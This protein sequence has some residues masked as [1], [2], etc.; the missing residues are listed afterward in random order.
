MKMALFVFVTLTLVACRDGDNDQPPAVDTA[1]SANADSMPN[2]GGMAT[3]SPMMK[4]MDAHMA[5]MDK[6]NPDSMSAMM[7]TH[8]Q[9][10]ANMLAQMNRDMQQMH[11]AADASWTALADS[12]R[13]DL[14]KMANMNRRD[15]AG[16][17]NGHMGRARRLMEL[18][19]RMM[20]D[21]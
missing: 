2:M 12:V 14:T 11:M 9:M 1:A 15:M 7:S 5:M 20:T 16:F 10:V 6:M 4:D 3:E 18:H 17:M 19:K 13:T 21:H 8:R